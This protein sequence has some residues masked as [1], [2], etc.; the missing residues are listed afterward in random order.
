MNFSLN[1]IYALYLKKQCD[2]FCVVVNKAVSEMTL[3]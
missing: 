2:S 3:W 1:V